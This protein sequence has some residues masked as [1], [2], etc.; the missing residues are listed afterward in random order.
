[1]AE[2]IGNIPEKPETT[3]ASVD[4]P[5]AAWSPQPTPEQH[6]RAHAEQAKVNS[7][8]GVLQDF[9]ADLAADIEAHRGIDLIDGVNPSTD[10]DELKMAVMLNNQ[11]RARL[12]E[13]HDKYRVRYSRFIEDEPL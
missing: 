2:D 10:G 9:F 8:I 3:D 12:I 1:M 13:L 4:S 7:S 5:F 11:V 6:A